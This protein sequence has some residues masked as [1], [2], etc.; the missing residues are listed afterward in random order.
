M[1]QFFKNWKILIGAAIIIAALSFIINIQNNKI[2]NLQN[3]NKRQSENVSSLMEENSSI[4]LTTSELKRFIKH[5]ESEHIIKIDSILTKH[6]IKVKELNKIISTKTTIVL[7]DT[8]YLV[9]ESINVKN[10]SLYHLQFKHENNCISAS[11]NAITKDPLTTI[12]FNEIKSKNESHF[13]VYKE[14][15]KWYQFFKK[16]KLIQKT[17]NNCG[18]TIIKELEIQ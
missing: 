15:K 4:K 2:N 16:R 10:D 14:P 8:V 17:I 3:D 7:K 1:V 12:N 11:V 5:S 13:I 6:D 18:E 9:A